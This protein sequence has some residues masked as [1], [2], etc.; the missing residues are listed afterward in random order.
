MLLYGLALRHGWVRLASCLVPVRAHLTNLSFQGCQINAELGFRYLQSAAEM[1][2]LDLDKAAAAAGGRRATPAAQ[3]GAKVSKNELMLALYEIG[4][5]FRFG[6]GVTK[7]KK[8]VS[9]L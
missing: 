6:W 7:D 5:S 8:M 1:V 9:L 4:T 2:T 3:D